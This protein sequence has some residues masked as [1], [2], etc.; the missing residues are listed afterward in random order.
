MTSL[1][2]MLSFLQESTSLVGSKLTSSP[3][4]VFI[5]V[6]FVKK[7]GKQ[8]ALDL[9]LGCHGLR[10]ACHVPRHQQFIFHFHQ[11][12]LRWSRAVTVFTFWKWWFGTFTWPRSWRLLLPSAN[13]KEH[14]TSGF[15]Q[16]KQ[17]N[18]VFFCFCCPYKGRN[19]PWKVTCFSLTL[20]PWWTSWIIALSIHLYP[21]TS[22]QRSQ[23]VPPLVDLLGDSSSSQVKCP[24]QFWTE[25]PCAIRTDSAAVTWHSYHTFHYVPSICQTYSNM[26]SLFMCKKIRSIAKLPDKW[27]PAEMLKLYEIITNFS[28]SFIKV[29]NVYL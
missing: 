14:Q 18:N 10:H 2:L 20:K 25:T 12:W 15:C 3:R 7:H 17:W 21:S 8:L 26:M 23:A 16:P 1:W 27:L 28:P 6:R 24:V 4:T 29:S 13:Q 9:V 5:S 19:I 11:Q 22:H